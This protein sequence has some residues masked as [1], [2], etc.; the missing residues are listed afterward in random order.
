VLRQAEAGNS[1]EA[2]YG[3]PVNVR[4]ERMGGIFDQLNPESAARRAEL[5]G[6]VGKTVGVTCQNGGNGRPRCVIDC[7]D[8][9]VSIVGRHRR[10]HRPEPSR[11]GAEE[12]G[13]VLKWGHE[14]TIAGREKQLES[15]VNGK[16]TGRH[17]HAFASDTGL[18]YCLDIMLNLLAHEPSFPLPDGGYSARPA[19]AQLSRQMPKARDGDPR[20]HRANARESVQVTSNYM[21]NLGQNA[22]RQRA[23]DKGQF[24]T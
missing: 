13:I 19:E 23:C 22:N 2:P 21:A 16:S 10:H 18:Q 6:T 14:D 4:L 5:D 3:A 8:A 24:G 7:V 15:E 20:N 11:E 12:H 1:A 9:H 17:E